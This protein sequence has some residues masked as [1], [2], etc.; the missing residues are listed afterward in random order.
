MNTKQLTQDIEF[1]KQDQ[2]LQDFKSFEQP[3]EYFQNRELT[4]KQELSEQFKSLGSK[5]LEEENGTF[6]DEFHNLLKAK[7]EKSNFVQNLV[8]WRG[9]QEFFKL[10]SSDQNAK[11]LLT[12]LIREL[13]QKADAE[14]DE[15]WLAVDNLINYLRESKLPAAQTKIWP[16]L[17]LFLWRPERFVFIKPTFMDSVLKRLD[18]EKL[19]QGVPLN[20]KLYRRV[21]EDLSQV[22]KGLAE[23]RPR[24][25]IDVQSFLWHVK[26]LENKR[27]DVK[28]IEESLPSSKPEAVQDLPTNLILYGP[29]GTGKTYTLSQEY[30]PGYMEGTIKRYEFVTFHQSYSYE[31]FVE[32]IRPTLDKQPEGHGDVSYV[33]SEGI[34]RRICERASVDKSAR[35]ALFIDEINRGNIS[36]IFGEL[37]TLIEE[38]KREGATNELSVVLPYSGD[39]FKVPGNLD[40][41]GTMNTAD[42]S[43]THIDTAL[44]RRFTFKEL[45]P[46]PDLLKSVQLGDTEINLE[47]ML[48]T[49]NQRIEA[50]FDR[51]HMIGHAYFLKGKGESINGE[52]LPTIFQTKIIPLLTEYFFDDWEK[53]R[54]V[55]AD[56][57]TNDRSAQFVT[58]AEVSEEI[59]STGSSSMYKYTY[60]LNEEA[61]S[62]PSS[63][64]KIYDNLPSGD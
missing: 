42:R 22:R 11:T 60:R 63:Y 2:D 59:V 53:V 47:S 26:D 19:G 8:N 28:P 44:R 36:K 34:F 25:Y 40:I 23:L 17:I 1:F 39:E 46:R 13:I 58:Q 50:L 45:V 52:E 43:L 29:P 30:F 37:I 6:L 5:L 20:G 3:G 61:L 48:S 21:M 7:L 9:I 33:L 55:L 15:V 31:E 12:H 62:N 51:E 49:I 38:D 24:D 4:Y 56:D 54:V 41:Y 27:S 32:G 18:F 64:L 35:Y 14:N 57:R 16:T 10:I